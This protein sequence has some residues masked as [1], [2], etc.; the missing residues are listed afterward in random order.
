MKVLL[1]V[2]ESEFSHAALETLIRQFKPQRTEVRILHVVEP[3]SISPPPQ[4]AAGY[5]P[6]LEG[7][8]AEAQKLVNKAGDMLRGAGFAVNTA[9]EQGEAREKIIDDATEWGADL[10]MTGSHGR[11]GLRRFLLGSVAES[12]AR[13]APCSVE[14]VRVPRHP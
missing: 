1:A 6:E 9:V 12:V 5:A 11:K 7:D 14:I 13:H 4:M 2:D 3:I 10:I 8:F